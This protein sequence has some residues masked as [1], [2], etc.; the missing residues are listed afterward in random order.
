M[1]AN[2]LT[3]KKKRIV[4]KP[5]DRSRIKKEGPENSGKDGKMESERMPSRSA[6]VCARDQRAGAFPAH[7][8]KCRNTYARGA[9][10]S[11]SV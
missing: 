7:S 8:L 2:N 11:G 5:H 1:G 3:L 4:W 9:V 6:V 10:L